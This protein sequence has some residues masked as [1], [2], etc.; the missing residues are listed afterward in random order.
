[1]NRKTLKAGILS[2]LLL[3]APS[4]AQATSGSLKVTSFPTGAEV[5]IDGVSTRKSTPM[6]IALPI[7]DHEVSVRILGSGWNPDTRTVTIVEGNND[8]SVTLLPTV[9]QGPP[10]ERGPQGERGEVGPRGELGPQGESGPRGDLG[11]RGLKGDAGE[12]GPQGPQG[13][14]GK[15][16]QPPA[17][18]P[19]YDETFAIVLNGVEA[20]QAFVRGC[21]VT[22]AV[23]AEG[24]G[25][26]PDS[27]GFRI[28]KHLG[29]GRAEPCTLR[30]R[31]WE[32]PLMRWVSDAV[33]LRP[34]ERTLE[35]VAFSAH[36]RTPGSIRLNRARVTGLTVPPMGTDG[37]IVYIEIGVTAESR[38]F[39]SDPKEA[40]PGPGDVY[41]AHPVLTIAGGHGTLVLEPRHLE[42]FSITINPDC[43]REGCPGDSSSPAIAY[44]D[45]SAVV[46]P[47]ASDDSLRGWLDESLRPH[48]DPDAQER[49][50]TLTLAV[51]GG[52]GSDP[53]TLHFRGAGIF[54]F[55]ALGIDLAGGSTSGPHEPGLGLR[56]LALYVESAELIGP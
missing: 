17:P 21:G 30:V 8:L 24:M 33:R 2:L 35:L 25:F 13:P 48:T 43:T 10:G 18:P 27:P 7:G 34:E 20:G 45:L 5:I 52:G 11:P 55:D 44:S 37:A 22:G 39:N 42:G 19:E 53:F 12:P 54:L 31:S 16:G 28:P 50:A 41:V 4:M 6:S 15:D 51:A 3:A 40:L 29:G 23:L 49:T 26:V 56:R 9:T 1:M 38:S 47:G 36:A 46:H 14:P 32:A